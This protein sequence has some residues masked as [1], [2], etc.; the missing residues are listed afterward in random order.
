MEAGAT[1]VVVASAR[2]K[3][4]KQVAE[5]AEQWWKAEE[6]KRIEVLREN[7]IQQAIPFGIHF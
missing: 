3:A 4:V 6:A 2:E 1:I 7:S 5:G